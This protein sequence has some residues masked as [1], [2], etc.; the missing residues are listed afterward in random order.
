MIS[1]LHMALSDRSEHVSTKKGPNNHHF[2]RAPFSVF[3]FARFPRTFRPI[4]DLSTVICGSKSGFS[5]RAQ[6]PSKQM[7]FRHEFTTCGVTPSFFHVAPGGECFAPFFR[8]AWG[9]QVDFGKTSRA[10]VSNDG[11]RSPHAKPHV[12]LMSKFISAFLSHT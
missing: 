4:P 11:T 10:S 6:R 3:F 9:M 7:N 5:K 8:W 2:A 12:V 1:R